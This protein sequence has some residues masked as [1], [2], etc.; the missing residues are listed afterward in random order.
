MF[1]SLSFYDTVSRLKIQFNTLSISDTHCNKRKI[2]RKK[3]LKNKETFKG[4]G[5]FLKMFS[6]L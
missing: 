3:K 1:V 5:Q 6:L 4:V 2:C